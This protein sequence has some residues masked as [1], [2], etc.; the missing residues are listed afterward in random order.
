MEK[1]EKRKKEQAGWGVKG[2]YY[3]TVN[4]SP[5]EIQLEESRQ[6]FKISK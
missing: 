1:K 2:V 5:T 6:L 4:P 3:Q